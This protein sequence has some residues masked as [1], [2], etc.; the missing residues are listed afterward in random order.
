MSRVSGGQKLVLKHEAP[1]ISFHLDGMSV[2]MIATGQP[3]H[4]VSGTHL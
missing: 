2:F 1:N 3:Q 4:Y